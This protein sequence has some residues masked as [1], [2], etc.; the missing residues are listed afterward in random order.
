ML[1]LTALNGEDIRGGRSLGFL[2][3]VKAA[4]YDLFSTE[5]Y[6]VDAAAR[7]TISEQTSAPQETV[8]ELFERTTCRSLWCLPIA[9]ED[10]H[11]S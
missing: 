11:M 5:P 1:T 8:A 6:G 10:D 4:D 7:R 9:D 3:Y 2:G